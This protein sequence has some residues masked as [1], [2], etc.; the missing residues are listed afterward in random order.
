MFHVMFPLQVITFLHTLMS[1]GE[2]TGVRTAAIVCPLN[3]V[4]NW[5]NEWGKWLTEDE[6]FDV[7][8]QWS[9]NGR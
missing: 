5:E 4:L 2:L 9:V 7:S 8:T 1:Y 3:T 6:Q